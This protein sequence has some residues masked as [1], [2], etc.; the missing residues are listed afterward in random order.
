MEAILE[1][2]IEMLDADGESGLTFRGLAAHMGAGVGSIYWY[3]AGKDELLS[4]ASDEVMA[5]VLPVIEEQ[6]ESEPLAALRAISIA[7]FEQ[8]EAHPWAAGHLMRDM[9]I[10]EHA[11]VFWEALGQQIMRLN[12][13]E[14]Q[15]FQAISAIIN[16]VVGMGAQ[17][18]VTDP[19]QPEPGE[20]PEQLRDRLLEEWVGVWMAKPA[21]EYPFS[22]RMA[23]LFRHHDDVEQ[24][25]GGLDLILSGLARQAGID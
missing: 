10:Q 14:R 7:L 16:Y 18:A 15:C 22:R 6:R 24:F 23:P 17:M 11:T 13:T 12:L 20:N 1:G 21:D 5:R 3:V 19:P 9:A 2:A 4:Y 8:M 25:V